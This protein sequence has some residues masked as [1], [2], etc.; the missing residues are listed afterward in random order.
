MVVRVDVAAFV[1]CE[2]VDEGGLSSATLVLIVWLAAL[3]PTTE[4]FL[5]LTVGCK[6]GEDRGWSSLHPFG[7]CAVD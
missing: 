2:M 4:E 3:S 7:A 6:V 5:C 1:V